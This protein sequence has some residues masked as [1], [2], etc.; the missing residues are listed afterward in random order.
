MILGWDLNDILTVGFMCAVFVVAILATRSNCN[1]VFK[2]E[3]KSQ[4]KGRKFVRKASI[5]GLLL[6][7]GF[8][9]I[10]MLTHYLG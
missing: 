9:V 4:E 10:S 7:V 2:G 5:V 1:W 8:T 6:T 3:E